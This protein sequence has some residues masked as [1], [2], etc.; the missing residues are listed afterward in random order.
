MKIFLYLIL[1]LISYMLNAASDAIDH[2]KGSKS[3]YELWHILK[4]ISY[5]IPF[6]IIL[7]EIKAQWYIWILILI[8]LG[9]VWENTYKICRKYKLDKFDDKIN[10]PI[11][12]WIFRLGNKNDSI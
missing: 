2:L 8:L 1:I 4:A 9:I 11:I 7:Y 12:R 10:L 5:A 3:L 6:A